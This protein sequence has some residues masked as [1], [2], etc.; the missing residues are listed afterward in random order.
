MRITYFTLTSQGAALAKQLSGEC[1]GRVVAKTDLGG[2]SFGQAVAQA[3]ECSEALVFIMATGIVVRTIA[4]LLR[5]KTCDPAVVVMDARG[6]FAISLV[7]G[8]LGGANGLARQLAAISGGQAVITTGTDVENTLAF[9]VLAKEN[10]LVIENIGELKYI[11]TAMIEREPVDMYCPYPVMFELPGN[12]R[13]YKRLPVRQKSGGLTAAGEA[14]GEDRQSAAGP[15]AAAAVFIGHG[16]LDPDLEQF[17][18]SVLYLRPKNLCMGIGCKKNIS[19]G[20][21]EEAFCE[22][23]DL[24]RKYKGLLAGIATIGLKSKEPAILQLSEKYS[25]PLYIIDDQAIK[26]LE[27]QG[28]VAVS[29]FVRQTTGVGSVS[30]GCALALAGQL[31]SGESAP[32]LLCPKT[33]Y[34]GITFALAAFEIVLHGQKG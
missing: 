10:H 23:Q 28:A 34:K 8:H 14:A 9:D 19:P 12:V 22:F 26:Q 33:K 24:N 5:S 17:Y 20:S 18:E 32:V 30:E 31:G 1:P 6:K 4:P 11:S 13:H 16:Y 27:D 21:M 7:S 25:L 3:W 15:P 2:Q 29:E